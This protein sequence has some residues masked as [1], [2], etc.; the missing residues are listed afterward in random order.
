MKKTV[1]ILFI[2]SAFLA[3]TTKKSEVAMNHSFKPGAIWFD[4]DSVHI[5]AHG[6]G[7]L[8]YEG[9]YYWYG[10]HKIAGEAGN[11]AHVGV[12]CYS[13][14]DLYNWKNEGIALSVVKT[15]TT[16]E[17]A[18]DCI[19]E[20]PKVIYNAKTKKFVMWFHLE[21]RGASYR[22]ARS[23]IAVSDSI[24]GTFTYIKSVRSN[25][26]VW[27]I[28]VS[29]LHK[30]PLSPE[31]INASFSGGNLPGHP[32]TVNI[33]GRD[34][35]TGQM[36]RDMTLFVDDD[37]KAYHLYASEENST[38]QIAE[39]TDD[40]LDHSGKYMRFFVNRFMEA[41]A[42][43]K[44]NGNYYFVASGCTGWD[45]NAARSA[46]ATSIWG[47]W[48]EMANPC[49][50]AD[51]ATTFQAQS[52]FILPVVGKKDAYIFMAD[53]W[54]PKDAIDGR[55]VWLPIE[56]DGKQLVIKWHNEWDLTVFDK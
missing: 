44:S 32:D 9:K 40:Y 42:I 41:P 43:F 3:C 8:F 51:S 53:R 23:G 31:L 45:P 24:T 49:F 14:T 55:Y 52:T 20:R 30:K 10:E 26:G 25:P 5:N 22:S 54:N 17:I 48:E 34:F 46:V 1:F 38:L 56:F 7:I 15:D 4:N 18:E 37:G 28:N 2:M 21:L 16:S 47:P 12:S 11:K 13:S 27:P 36:Q 50:G 6:G 29:D 35:A 39:L 33:L 19:L